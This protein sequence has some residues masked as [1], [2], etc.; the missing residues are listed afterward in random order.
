MRTLF[1]LCLLALA[2]TQGVSAQSLPPCTTSLN[3]SDDND[4][5]PQPMDIDKDN[6]GLIEICDL[7]GL[8]EMRHQLDGSG[9][10]TSTDATKI[11]IG[12]PT[13]CSGFELMRDLD[14]ED[15]ASYRTIANRTTWTQ[16]QGWQPIAG[17]NATFDGSGYT[18]S[19]L[20]INRNG[21]DG[22]GLFGYTGSNSTLTAVG[23]LNAEISGQNRVGGLVGNNAG[24]IANSY[25]TGTVSGIGSR[26]GGLAGGS[27]TNAIIKNSCA[28]ATVSRTGT[29]SGI[30]NPTGGLVGLNQGTI[31]NSCA[32]GTVSGMGSRIGGLVGF[33]DNAAIE[34]SYATGSVSGSFNVGGLVGF[35][36]NAAI[37]NSY[38]TGSVSGGSI[39][40]GGLVGATF[41]SSVIMKSY[42]TGSVS[43]GSINVGGLVGLLNTGGTISN[44]YW[45]SGPASSGG[46]NVSAN[47]EKTVMELTS[48]TAAEGIYSTWSSNDWDFGTSDQFPILN[49]ILTNLPLCTLNILADDRDNVKHAMD[50]DKDNDGLIEICDLEGLDEMRYQLDG[51]GYRTTPNTTVIT[52]GCPS[53]GCR[54]YEL[55]RN[56]D[57]M[58]DDNYRRAT[59]KATW[60]T[61]GG[62]QPVGDLA[63]LF[64]AV[65]DGNGHTIS[66]LMVNRSGTTLAGL[67]GYTETSAEIANLGLLD[68]N[69]SGLSSVGGLVGWNQGSIMSSYVMGTVSGINR[70]VGGLVGSNQGRIT[71]SYATSTVSGDNRN[72]GGLVGFNDNATIK[73][74]YATGNVTGLREGTGGLVGSNQGRITSSYA[75]ARSVLGNNDV[76]GLAGRNTGT[77]NDSYWRF[78][79]TSSA[80]TDVATDTSKTTVELTSPTR[81]EGIYVKWE[82]DDWDFGTPNQF[83][84]L[85]YVEGIDTNY[86]A[87]SDTPPLTVIDQPQCETLLPHQ[88]MNIGDRDSGLRESLRE[89]DISGPEMELNM[90]FGVSTNNY[91]VTIFLREGINEGSVVLRLR[92][93]NP[94]A[95]IQIFR[96]EDS[97][98]Y[99]AG[100]MSGDES[101]PIAVVDGTKLTIRTSEPDTD[102]MLTF[103]VE[104]IQSVSA[105]SLPPCT[106]SLNILDD[107]DGIPQAMDID[108]DG[109]GLIEICDLE[110]LDEMRH[111]LD[112]SGYTTSTD[113]MKITDGCPSNV[114]SGFELMR[115][116]DFEDPASYR[117]GSI[118]QAWTS[119]AGWD[120]IGVTVSNDLGVFEFDGL[121]ATFDGNGYTI[122]NLLINRPRKVRAGF[123]LSI[124]GTGRIDNMR[125][126]DVDV[127]GGASTAG[128]AG[129]NFGTINNAYVS[130]TIT[131]TGNAV[132]GLVGDNRENCLINNSYAVVT[133]SG[134]TGNR[135]VSV[136]GLVG[137]NGCT[138]TNSYAIAD[139][140]GNNGVGGLVGGHGISLVSTIRNSFAIATVRGNE[141]VGGLVGGFIRGEIFNS[142]ARGSVFAT[143]TDV[144]GLVGWMGDSNLQRINN[145]YSIVEVAGG[146]TTTIIGGL[147][148]RR[149]M[150]ANALIDNS[151]WDSQISGQDTSDGGSGKTT[152]E[153]QEPTTNE[154]IYDSWSTDDWDFGSTVQYPRLK[155]AKGGDAD[156]PMCSEDAGDADSGLPRCGDLLPDQDSFLPQ[157]T[158]SLNI[159]DDNDGV[160]QAIDTD[161]DNDGLIEICDL[162]GLN[163]IRHQLDGTGYK[164]SAEATVITDGC[165]STCTGFELTRS[166]DFMDTSSYGSGNINTVWTQGQGWQPIGVSGASFSATFNGNGY[167]ISNLKIN[168]NGTDGVGLFG[169]TGSNSTLTAVGLLNAE[170]SGQNRI[171]GLVG[172]NAGVITNSYVTGT[173]S[174]SGSS[175]GGLVGGNSGTLRDSCATATVSRTGTVSGVGNPTGGLVGLNQGT[176][177]NSCATGTVSGVGSRIGGLVG[178]HQ[179]GTIEN[180][181]ATGS[182][183][184]TRNQIGG[185]V[186]F[187]DNSTIEN[188]YATGSV[189]GT[190]AS[191]GGLVGSTLNASKIE[192]SYATGSVSGGVN[193]GGLVGL[194]NTGGTIS[195]SYWLSSSASSGGANVPIDTEKTIMALTSP[196]AAEGIY[197]TW[198]TSDW[199]FGTSNQFPIIR[200]SG[201]DVL[202]NLPLC[203]LNILADDRDDVKHAMDIDKDNDNL[204]EICDVEGLD[205][206]RYQLDGVGYKTTDSEMVVAITTGCS[207]TC[208]GFE[209]ARNLDFMASDSYRPA[210]NEATWTT[211]GGWRPVGDLVV[212]FDA[213][214]DGN[215][216]TISNLMVNKSDT[217]LAGL[218]GYTET[219]AEIANLGLLDVNIRGLSSVGGLTGWNQGSI[220]GS[221]VTGTVSGTNRSVGSLVG[222]NQGRITR[223]Y[224]TSTVSGMNRNVG[225]LVGFNNNAT[226]KNSYATGSVSGTSVNVGGLVGFNDNA[227]IENSYATAK[228]VSGNNDVGGL[229]GKNTGTI[230][231]SYW[232]IGSTTNAGT[233]VATDT[234]KT[235]VELTSPTA[236]GGIYSDWGADD[237]DFGT[238]NQFPALKYAKSIDTSY[239]TCSDTAPLTGIDRPQCGTLLPHQ[240]MDIGNRGSGLRES[241]R[242]LDISGPEMELN[243]PLGVSTNNYVVTIFLR[244]GINEGSVVLR[245]RAYNPDAEIQI[246][247]AEDSIDYFAGKMSGD[248]SLPIA[249]VD[250]TKL[251]IRVSEP[252]TDYTLTFR[253]DEFQGIQV[254]VRVFLEGPLQ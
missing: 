101:L 130:G 243:M 196:T 78:G 37:E 151:Y 222:S 24:V 30:G 221:Y 114:C 163:A 182:V 139:V 178:Q 65:F 121:R 105:Q 242:E 49:D 44:S 197:S 63:M 82:P 51:A 106:T 20:M 122:S 14:F 249:V 207:T 147:V 228:S 76:G 50:V 25:A 18:I 62:W 13:A 177:T 149:V 88:G 40:V 145:S 210:T 156:N 184:G 126:K 232:R 140:S 220:T 59:N 42:A 159:P 247:R 160:P 152:M 213:T 165:P 168:R 251:T 231:D 187:N 155:Y 117:S 248:E 123:F 11:T 75:T 46:T 29:V 217:T 16:G 52:T 219:S 73:N 125:L 236:A 162:E 100:K 79:S 127:T 31:T 186:G 15:P 158:I 166:L 102:Y 21:T 142:Y 204:I 203:T 104:E 43:G 74:S 246:F 254:R 138:I 23:L 183:S 32:T 191:V 55:A 202:T 148:G 69:I 77:I 108:K 211:G 56:L 1:V 179:G 2:G 5:V 9:Y 26:I 91:V 161:K 250:G 6:N 71:S 27:G 54:G 136:G 189:S 53:T 223:S 212:L 174:G 164:A 214:F 95:E 7:E 129:A 134:G 34:N 225:G 58:A 199:D 198:S 185:L 180:S 98:D 244:E 224:A 176:I 131:G 128:L 4:G 89:L 120:P 144:G 60:T 167:T 135:D 67:F 35:N 97:T 205:E 150:A 10:T 157:C 234:S 181:Y 137:D 154:G 208:T 86:Q 173:V 107:N 39:N 103:R 146:A 119:G 115:D 169:Y 85:K 171:G 3:I 33:N 153:L 172:N 19:N 36:D 253:V 252:D 45:L 237:W 229:A 116:L 190:G 195:N 61:G 230:N 70:S 215:G 218:F 245:L 170:I 22:V 194:L 113:A 227:T 133:V 92:A 235:T 90:P 87:C 109:D 239:P 206:M 64:N 57:F 188:S 84:A 193:I 110:G 80:G 47:T 48:P 99:F 94:D 124:T 143:D 233:D 96:A 17:F 209:L 66:N 111:Q 83:P 241:L 112:G 200:N 141:L 81:A 118:N 175:V 240:G 38:A 216:Y 201:S 192:N 226:I 28:T 8:D 132:G 72:V 93:Y 238:P 12:C 41:M 68:V